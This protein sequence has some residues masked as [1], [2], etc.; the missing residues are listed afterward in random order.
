VVK[1]MEKHRGQIQEEYDLV[2]TNGN[3]IGIAK[4]NIKLISM[5]SI[6]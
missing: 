4:S 5:I 6:N 1:N 3:A 2:M